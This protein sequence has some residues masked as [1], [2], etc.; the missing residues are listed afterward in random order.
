MHLFFSQNLIK[1]RGLYIGI[2]FYPVFRVCFW[3]LQDYNCWYFTLCE[4]YE[5]TMYPK[6]QIYLIINF[7]S[8]YMYLNINHLRPLFLA[9][10]KFLPVHSLLLYQPPVDLT[11]GQCLFYKLWCQKNALA[12]CHTSQ[13]IWVQEDN[14]I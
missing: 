5:C 4:L 7:I 13:F 3:M 9:P 11:H 2:K 1:R 12:S 6:H 14:L 10:K 8:M